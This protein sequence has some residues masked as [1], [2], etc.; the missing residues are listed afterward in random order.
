MSHYLIVS[1]KQWH[2]EL[3]E[4]LQQKFPD[5]QWTLIQSAEHFSV[6]RLESLNPAKIFIPHWSRLIPADVYERY[7]CV[8]FHMTDLPYGRGGSPLQNLIVRGHTTTK[9]CALQVV[10]KIDAGPVYLKH[11]LDLSGTA[12]E[13]FDRA[14][15][16]IGS[17]IEEIV[18]NQPIATPQEG[19]PTFF[20]RRKPEESNLQ[21]VKTIQQI[22]DY[23]RM[24]D[25]EGYPAAFLE[26]KEARY[27]FYE[28]RFDQITNSIEAHVRITKK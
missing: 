14:S 19:E 3:L 28:A 13:I 18:I 24:L 8:V 17:M 25:C 21:N 12:R 20:S 15:K 27:E 6:E 10:E 11:E 2:L 9:I 7:E 16:T 1:E 23:I 26:T 5:D 22:Y 4:Q